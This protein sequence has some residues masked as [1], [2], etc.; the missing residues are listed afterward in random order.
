MNS[1]SADPTTLFTPFV[2]GHR[3]CQPHL[4]GAADRCRATPGTDA[5]NALIAEYYAQRASAGLLVTEGTQILPSGKGYMG[6][7]G[8]TAPS[9]R[10]AGGS[11]PMP[12]TP[13]AARSSPSSGTSAPSRTLTCNPAA[14]CR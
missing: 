1:M 6:T 2:W 7:P 10:P 5:A 11:P 14:R 3:S 12:C 13:K 4:H 9:R 8:I